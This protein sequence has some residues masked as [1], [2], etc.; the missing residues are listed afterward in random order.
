[1]KNLKGWLDV[2]Y[3]ACGKARRAVYAMFYVLLALFPLHKAA[4]QVDADMVTLM[5]RNALSVDDYLTAIRYFNQA[6]EAKPYL[7]RPYY[8]RAYAKFTLEDYKGAEA[9]CAKSIELNPFIVEVYQLRGLC[10]IHNDNYKGAADDYTRVLSEMPDDQG[11]RYNRALCYLQ[12]KDYAKA[13]SD[14]TVMINRWPRYYRTYL[15]KAQVALEQKDTL[16]A[17]QWVDTLLVKNPKE[18]NAWSFKGRYAL[19]NEDYGLADSCLTQ[20]IL[21]LPRDFELFVCRAQARHALDRFGLAI[22]DY[23]RAI[24][25]QPSHFV[26]HYNRGLLRTQVGEDNAAIEDF[27]F[28]L[29]IEDTDQG[30]LV[31]GATDI[32]YG[33]LRATGLTW[34]EGPDIGGPVGPYVQSQRM[35][36]FRQ[37]AEQ[38]VREGKAYYCFCTEERLNALHEQ[39]KANGEVSHYDGC[40]RR[41]SQ[42]EID[43]KLAAGTP[44]VIRQKIPAEGVTGFDD[45]VYGHIEVSNAELDDQI[46]IKTDGMPT[47]NF[48]NVVDDHLMG[49]THVI[50]GSE[51]LSSTPKYNLLY[52]AFGW[53]VPAYIHC[54]PVMKDAQ[55][56]LS[57]R[58][59]D[60]SYQDL[61]A[62][63]YLPAAVL[64]YLLL[65]GWAPEGEQEIFS[66]DEMVKIWDP[67]RISKSPAIFDPLKLRAVNAAYIRALPAAEFRRL[68]DPFI[69][70]AVHADIDRDLLCANLQPRCEVLEDIPPQL[71][72]FDAPLPIDPELYRSK[73]QK[74][75]PETARE[76]LTALLPVLEAQA[77]WSREAIFET[78]RAE[79]ER[80]EKKNGWLLFPL[81]IALSG[82]SRTP[83]GGTDLAAMM[84][85]DETVRRVK[86]AVKALESLNF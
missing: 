16:R 47:Y 19:Q 4:A 23:D 85:K 42:T 15:V 76:A 24:E 83:G 86:A 31:E 9:D 78:C 65:L 51:Y 30:R 12:E 75:T 36:M 6:I 32:I 70:R 34:D 54:P 48:A 64:N 44:Y 62:K 28:I 50:R 69:D 8:Y 1:M 59:G 40:C 22:A 35:G 21:Y 80:L 55:H 18:G 73:K 20:A 45:V 72:F 49:I 25:L 10:R 81:G 41:L 58:N 46:L 13:D 79:A 61:V 56:K 53:D 84:G 82:K 66:L 77:D 11:S 5:G 52:Q 37:Y 17:M 27:D 38:L 7:S 57:K 74:T 68:A 67:A 63:G 2:A 39:Q 14:L 29:R 71:D 26:A 60:A 33:T 43:E 3:T